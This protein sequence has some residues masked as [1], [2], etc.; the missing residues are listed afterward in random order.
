M[1]SPGAYTL[2]VEDRSGNLTDEYTFDSGELIVGRSRQCDIVLPSENVSRRHARIYTTAGGLAIEDLQSAN[3]VFV[4]GRHVDAAAVH[5]HA[6][7]ERPPHR[8]GDRA[9]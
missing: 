8:H 6:V 1:A 5:E 3:G 2:V 7:R 4:N 9:D